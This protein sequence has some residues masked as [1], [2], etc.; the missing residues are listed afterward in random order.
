MS[1]SLLLLSRIK[2][3]QKKRPGVD[4]YLCAGVTLLAT[5]DLALINCP[6]QSDPG[7]ESWRQTDTP[8]ARQMWDYLIRGLSGEQIYNVLSCWAAQCHQALKIAMC[9]DSASCFSVQLK[10]SLRNACMA[11][12]KISGNDV[13]V[14]EDDEIMVHLSFHQLWE[15]SHNIVHLLRTGF[16]NLK[17]LY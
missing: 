15:L 9:A 2:L 17:L 8:R 1:N 12:V 10:A 6:C 3:M 5:V 13:K 11:P 14:S 7:K 4:F 16:C